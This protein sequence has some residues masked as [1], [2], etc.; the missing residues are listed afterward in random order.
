MVKMQPSIVAQL[1]LDDEGFLRSPEA[2]TEEIAQFLAGSE[3]PDGLSEAH[4]KL[5]YYLRQYYLDNGTV[6]PLL[7]IRRQAG[8]NLKSIYKL[9]PSGLTKGVCKIAGIPRSVILPNY[10]YP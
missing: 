4:W 5:I 10:L 9:F 3:V 6:P 1:D 7:M 2:W 8:F